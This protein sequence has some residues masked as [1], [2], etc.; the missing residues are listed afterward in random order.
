MYI[1]FIFLQVYISDILFVN[2]SFVGLVLAGAVF[3]FLALHRCAT[4]P[5]ALF[6]LF[7]DKTCYN[8][9]GSIYRYPSPRVLHKESD[10]HES[11]NQRRY[12][13]LMLCLLLLHDERLC[14]SVR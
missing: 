11:K 12:V 8:N 13:H 3:I 14:S 7:F 1:D 10:Y 6:L 5:T 9:K 2:K 4:L